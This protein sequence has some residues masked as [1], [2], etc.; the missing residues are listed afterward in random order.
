MEQIKNGKKLRKVDVER[1]KKEQQDSWVDSQRK[2]V[3][4]VRSLEDTISEFLSVLLFLQVFF[5]LSVVFVIMFVSLW[6]GD[7]LQTKFAFEVEFEDD[8]EEDEDDEE[9]LWLHDLL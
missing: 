6:T 4:M 5:V 2:S 1:L 9:W 8:E 7:A 3:M